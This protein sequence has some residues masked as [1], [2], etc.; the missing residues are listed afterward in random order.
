MYA[1]STALYS[2]SFAPNYR[3]KTIYPSGA[4]FL[5]YLETVAERAGISSNIQLNSEVTMVRWQN[6]SAE[7]ELSVRHKVAESAGTT[8]YTVQ[9]EVIRAKIVISAVGILSEPNKPIAD[10]GAF[11]G[12]VIHSARWPADTDLTGQDIVIVGSGCSAAQII[13]AL[14]QTPVKS[15]TQIMRTAPWV[16]PRL[17]EPGGK[18]AYAK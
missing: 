6:D 10:L 7:W 13:H 12:Q 1:R 4:D 14:L 18:E 9:E 8:D 2:F 11:N 15:L 16:V 17:E 5:D 3:S